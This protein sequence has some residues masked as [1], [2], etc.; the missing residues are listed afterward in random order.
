M[1]VTV[2]QEHAVPVVPVGPP[3]GLDLG[4]TH[5]ATLSTGEQIAAPKPL[6]RALRK[7]ARQQR[8]VSRSQRNSAARRKKVARLARI[9]AKVRAVR[10]DFL[11]KLSYRLATEHA[12]V[13]VESLN[14]SGML[15]NRRLSRAIS[16]LGWSEFIRQLQYKTRW[17][18]STLVEAGRFFP[19]TKTCSSCG[20]VVDM[21]LAQRTYACAA[22]GLVL[23]RDL[24]AARNLVP[25]AVTPTETQNAGGGNV[26]PGYAWQIPR[27]PEPS[28]P[29]SDRA[30]SL[31]VPGI[32]WCQV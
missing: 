29:V 26:S 19:S 3:V 1:S 11:H 27:K 17:Y 4:I 15:K 2:E 24:N 7:L 16:D 22:C 13:G 18:G 10:S 5:F 30:I 31:G 20:A 8:A 9:H 28:T 6:A 25:V 14:V 32:C 12:A 21:P 23:D